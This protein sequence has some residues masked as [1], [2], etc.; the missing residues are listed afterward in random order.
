MQHE[1][2]L[3]KPRSSVVA[4][5]GLFLLAGAIGFPMA[6][7]CLYWAATETVAAGGRIFMAL[8]GLGLGYGLWY[9]CRDAFR[10]L[11]GRPV[12]RVGPESLVVD[13]RSALGRPLEIPRDA[14]RAAALELSPVHYACA[15]PLVG[16]NPSMPDG[17][18]WLAGLESPLPLAG[19]GDKA[20]NVALVFKWPV[21]GRG[22]KR[23]PGLLM[24]AQDPNAA[25][26]ALESWGVVRQLTPADGELL[27]AGLR[28]KTAPGFA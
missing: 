20:P 21:T 25:A 28:G 17:W 3:T 7:M 13:D 5:I 14:V 2:P 16:A 4:T 12:L 23:L 10:K 24:R 9:V 1:V 11:A 26:A 8:L 15:F 27:L 6:G 18:L 22:G 19:A